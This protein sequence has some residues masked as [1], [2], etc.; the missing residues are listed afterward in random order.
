MPPG[1]AKGSSRLRTF[2]VEHAGIASNHQPYFLCEHMEDYGNSLN[3]A[4]EPS[5]FGG[6]AELMYLLPGTPLFRV[7]D[8]LPDELAVLTEV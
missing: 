2:R 3:V 7:P 8:E 4:R 6:W 1:R 5:L